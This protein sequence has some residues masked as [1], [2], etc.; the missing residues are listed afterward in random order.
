MCCTVIEM[1]LGGPSV[2]GF[3]L[4]RHDDLFPKGR[5]RALKASSVVTFLA[6]QSNVGLHHGDSF[7][8]AIEE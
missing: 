3:M 7:I 6:E 5:N 2:V 1:F 8:D 4:R